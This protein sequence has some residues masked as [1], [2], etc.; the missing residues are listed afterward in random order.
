MVCIWRFIDK[1]ILSWC[2][3]LLYAVGFAL[4]KEKMSQKVPASNYSNGKLQRL[5]CLIKERNGFWCGIPYLN[6]LSLQQKKNKIS[7]SKPSMSNMFFQ[8][9]WYFEQ[10]NYSSIIYSIAVLISLQTTQS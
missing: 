1:Y 2:G 7:E 3:V 6:M 4:E 8:I 5:V 9:M 10:H